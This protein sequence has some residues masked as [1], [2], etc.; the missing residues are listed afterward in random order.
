MS[1]QPIQPLR[2]GTPLENHLAECGLLVKREDLSCPAPGPPFSKTRGV[3]SHVKARVEAGVKLFGVLDTSHSQAGHAV[4]HATRLLGADCVNFFPV[5]KRDLRP[6]SDVR[7]ED[8][9]A[10]VLDDGQTVKL[11]D[12]QV[13]SSRLGARLVGLGAGRSAVLYHQAKK[14]TEALGGY[15]MPNA[16]KLPE[17]LEETAAE[18]V[19]TLEG[20]SREHFEVM[21][22]V[23]WIIS[24]SSATIASGVLAGLCDVFPMG[25]KGARHPRLILHMGYSRSREAVYKYVE[26]RFA[27]ARRRSIGLIQDGNMGASFVD[28][29]KVILAFVDEGYA[30]ADQAKPG[31]TPPWPCNPYYDLKALRWWLREGRDRY[32]GRA[33]FWNVG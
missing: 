21:R 16:L 13:M 26:K 4:A 33:V 23:P 6:A 10:V 25:E 18:V 20:A 7:E 19:R 9:P 31:P 29:T 15:T 30:Y 24:C 14:Q 1:S 3:F 27:L 22:D 5:Y 32:N 11:R 17:T 28:P 8:T 12:P 2:L